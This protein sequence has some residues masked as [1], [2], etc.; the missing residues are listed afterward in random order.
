MEEYTAIARRLK[1]NFPKA[2]VPSQPGEI[3]LHCA[4]RADGTLASLVQRLS[5]LHVAGDKSKRNQLESHRVKGEGGRKWPG[6]SKEESPAR[7]GRNDKPRGDV[8]KGLHD[9][10]RD[11]RTTRKLKQGCRARGRREGGRLIKELIPW[12]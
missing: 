10:S 3:Q 7:R 11:G 9:D 6:P 2:V 12:E 5:P 4:E 1:R 8:K